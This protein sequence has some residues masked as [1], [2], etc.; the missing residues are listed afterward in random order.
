MSEIDHPVSA[1]PGGASLARFA[2]TPAGTAKTLAVT[3]LLRELDAAEARYVAKILTGDLRIGLKEGLVEDAIAAAFAAKPA[4][5]RKA[6]QLS[7]D[8]GRTAV[9]AR[10]ER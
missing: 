8:L 10:H 6:H 1:E 4:E 9:G 5:V 2:S 3:E 7:G